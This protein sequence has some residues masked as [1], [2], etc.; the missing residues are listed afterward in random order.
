MQMCLGPSRV[1]YALRTLPL[2]E[3]TAFADAVSKV[4]REAFTRLLGGNLS[5]SGWQQASLPLSKG[6]CG[7][8]CAVFLAP[9][10]RLAGILQFMAQTEGMLECDRS[11]LEGVVAEKGLLEALSA[12]CPKTS[13]PWRVGN[14]RAC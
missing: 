5:D 2:R 3:T 8:S 1:Q 10:A 9:V 4:H 7:L 13:S 6:G 12:R 11:W 14:G